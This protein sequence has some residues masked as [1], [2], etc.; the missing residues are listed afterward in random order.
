MR[1]R[2]TFLM[3]LVAGFLFFGSDL[4]MAQAEVWNKSHVWNADRYYRGLAYS[5][6]N[7]HLYV[8]GT[9]GAY[10]GDAGGTVK[11]DSKIQ[12]LD[13][14]TGDSVTTLSPASAMGGDW[15]YGIR[16]VEVDMEGGI[17]ATTGTSNQYNP[18]QLYYWAS[19]D[20]E[21]VQLWKDASG[22]ADDFG[23]SFSVYGSFSH[24]AL[25]IIP[26][27]NVAKVYYFEV[28]DGVLGEV[29]TLDLTGLTS[30][31]TPTVQALGAKIADGFWYNNVALPGPVKFDGSGNITATVPA[32]VFATPT[33]GDCKF[34]QMAPFEALVISDSGSVVAINI[35]GKAADLSDVTAA[36]I[37][38]TL[39][40]TPPIHQSIWPHV[41]G[42]GQEQIA[43][44]NPDG[45]W[46][47]YSLS[48][49]NYVAAVAGDGAPTATN[50][51]FSGNPVVAD[52][53]TAEYQYIDFNNDLEGTSEIKWY[54][55]DDDEGTG[56]AE[57]T[58]N[59]GNLTYTLDAVDEGKYI[60]F[61]VL[62][63]SSTGATTSSALHLVESAAF[64][65]VLAAA[66]PPVASD[67]AISG[68]L[69][70]GEILTGSYT[71]SDANGDSEGESVIEW[72][73]ADETD[74]L[75]VSSG[76]LEYTLV[77]ADTGKYIILS[78][79][80]VA[81]A[82]WFT[83]GETVSAVTADTV[84]PPP[85]I[86]PVASELGITGREEVAGILTGSYTYTDYNGDAEAETILKWYRADDAIGTGKVEIV[87]DTNMYTVAV[88]D[89]AKYILF[90]V[91]PISVE[92]V[93]IDTGVVV[94]VA[95]GVIGPEPAAEAPVA[96]DVMIHG[97]AEVGVVL[98]GTY[99]YTDRTDDPEGASVHSWYTAD[100]TLGTNLAP[101]AG[102][103]DNALL[104]TED[105][106]GSYVG[107]G[108]TP[109]ATVGD[110]L[111][112]ELVIVPSET[113][114]AASTNDGDFERVWM[115]AAKHNA[116][117]EY[118]GS[119]NTERGFAVGADHIY[120]A[121]R[122]GGTNLLVVDKSDGTLITKMNTEGMDAGLYKIS[123]VEVSDDG[124][125]L[126]CPLTLNAS[127]ATGWGAGLFTIYKW[128]DE[129]SAPVKWIE[130]QASEKMRLGDKF[131]VTGDVSGDAVI[132]AAAPEG[133]VVRW[134]VT[135][136][137]PDTGTELSLE[138]LSTLGVT[139]AVVPF[140]PTA[141]SDFLVDAR[142]LQAQIFD[143]D[144]MSVGA[145]EGVGKDDNQSNS[146]NIFYH[147]GRTLAA[148][149]QKT[150]DL[151]WNVIVKDITAAPF[152]TVG[153]SEALSFTDQELGGVHVASDA[154]FFYLYMLSANN[155][156]AHFKGVLISPEFV[157]AES[158]ETG[159]S[160]FVVFSKSMPD[161][162][163]QSTGWIVN[164]DG[165][166]VAIDTIIGTGTAPEVLTFVLESA[167][168]EGQSITIEYDGTGT[169][170]AADAQPLLAFGPEN[171]VNIVGAQ[172]PVATDA[173]VTGDLFVGSTLT[174]TYTYAD[175]NG[176]VEEGSAY[177]WYY[178]SDA[179]G[180]DALKLLGENGATY[181]VGD[182]MREK[183]VAFEVTPATATGGMNYLVGE[184]VMSEFV[185][186][187]TVG[188]GLDQSLNV[189]VYPNPF[190][191]TLTI[192]NC[193]SF[194]TIA[195]IDITGRVQQSVKTLGENRIELNMEGCQKGVYFLKL[196][197]VESKTEVV[198]IVKAQ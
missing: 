61:T 35:T 19:E 174:G 182:D 1:K 72:Y 5:P 150:E 109:V 188:I 170:A 46:A 67:V 85:P 84:S 113:V 142:G 103:D 173:A 127:A 57:I 24:E 87:A 167:A 91:T 73:R 114:V 129:L 42:N 37:L 161:T 52:V 112:G 148:F 79:T 104:V 48:G 51:S 101:V 198:R 55:A 82:G 195:V 105:M 158:T 154:D 10:V 77:D 187:S 175:A 146:P 39:P 63:V 194:E 134:I 163:N 29:K 33:T 78:V 38:M 190:A 147:K 186:I 137:I 193:S 130:Y 83:I 119:G 132:Y 108:I 156:V 140:Q 15:G 80:P 3:M 34:V 71:Y 4:A 155:G 110:L 189:N 7:N 75:L 126:A 32:E 95:T 180:S 92:T 97:T 179:A 20:A 22:T 54:V 56:K 123:D 96:T 191:N 135:G 53:I 183:Y 12:V 81:E 94:M 70:A 102:A 17:Y 58:A 178:A 172:V 116:I 99:T 65:P 66:N 26:F 64:G 124:Q 151:Q 157:S 40:G 107:Y 121:S 196:T 76:G 152:A 98:Y 74:T 184:P 13:A 166:P 69:W 43:L 159:D 47:I 6:L 62:P 93:G 41:Y 168:T 30:V 149:H 45:G 2:F 144:G 9:E 125:I 141:D 165:A 171:V 177:Q 31:R 18:V 25:I 162:T 120:I 122:N 27:V 181:V 49:G 21:P 118:M 36:D 59:A 136:G 145:I 128:T 131:T 133:K 185:Q 28:V 117:P 115:R 89:E 143:K 192:D 16:D 106:I 100:D 138:G 164:V 14:A 11:E 111:T 60:S 90:E 50:L 68:T 8:G 169:A 139:P 160:L 86:P 44:G 23:G 197:T 153:T 88:E 176:D